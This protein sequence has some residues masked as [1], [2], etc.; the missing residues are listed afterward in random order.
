MI[1]L[2]MWLAAATEILFIAAQILHRPADPTMFITTL[3]WP[4][5]YAG[6][7]GLAF[8]MAWVVKTGGFGDMYPFTKAAQQLFPGLPVRRLRDLWFT[9]L[10]GFAL[11]AFPLVLGSMAAVLCYIELMHRR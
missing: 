5:Y 7:L 3:G 10:T 11:F 8:G 2:S 6:C 1:Y 9:F 4:V